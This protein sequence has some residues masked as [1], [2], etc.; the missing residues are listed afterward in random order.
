[1][2]AH[3]RSDRMSTTGAS[4]I[5]PL[6]PAQMETTWSLG[7]HRLVLS[8]L[9]QLDQALTALQLRTFDAASRS[10]PKAANASSSRYWARS[11]HESARNLTHR[12]CWAEPRLQE[13]EIPTFSARAL[14]GV[15]EVGLRE[16]L[17]VGDGDDV[18]GRDER[19]RR[20]WPSSRRSADPSSNRRPARREASRSASRRET[21]VRG[22][23]RH[24]RVGLAPRRDAAE[25]QGARRG[26]RRPASEGRRR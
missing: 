7:G 19:G 12:L 20:R 4:S 22:R 16:A 1:M 5:L 9:E 21:R 15:E 2:A 11:R 17:T 23:R 24:C 3:A 14:T 10:E 18:G 25:Q 13:T 8:L 6:V 26:R